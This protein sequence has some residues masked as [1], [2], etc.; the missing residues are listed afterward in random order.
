MPNPGDVVT[1]ANCACCSSSS[2]SSK[3]SSSSSGVNNPCCPGL[4]LP[5]TLNISITPQFGCTCGG[6]TTTITRTGPLTWSNP[7]I[8]LACGSTLGVVFSCT[9]TDWHLVMSGCGG[10][11]L[12]KSG[13]TA[14]FSPFQQLF[15]FLGSPTTFCC[16][17]VGGDSGAG[18]LFVITT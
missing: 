12:P 5:D 7:S 11:D 9:G 10:G 13:N 6:V 4:S 2:S 1:F 18:L 3:G 16:N 15:I 17:P 14:S 8:T